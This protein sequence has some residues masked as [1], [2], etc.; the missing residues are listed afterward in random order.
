MYPKLVGL[1]TRAKYDTMFKKQL[2]MVERGMKQGYVEHQVEVTFLTG[3][4]YI[5]VRP[6]KD[7]GLLIT[8]HPKIPQ[9]K[10]LQRNKRGISLMMPKNYVVEKLITPVSGT[11]YLDQCIGLLCIG[12]TKKANILVYIIFSK[13]LQVQVHIAYTY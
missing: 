8:R 2:S 11:L 7:W 6:S 9:H 1:L 3:F 13:R 5:I 10:S 4:S 12:N